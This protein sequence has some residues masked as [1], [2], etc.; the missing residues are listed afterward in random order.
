MECNANSLCIDT[1]NNRLG[2]GTAVPTRSLTLDGQNV[3]SS[4]NY[5]GTEKWVMGNEDTVGDRFILYTPGTGYVMTALIG[6]NVGIGTTTP[7]QKLEVS[8]TILGD[9]DV[10]NGSGA[11]LSQLDSFIGSQ[12]IAGGTNHSRTQCTSAGGI[13]VTDPNYANPI[14]RFTA[15]SCPSGWAQFNSYSTN[16]T[17]TCSW[18]SGWQVGSQGCNCGGYSS[19][20]ATGN[21]WGNLHN[22]CNVPSTICSDAGG[23]HTST[24]YTCWATTTQIGCY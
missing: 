2:I 21:A 12:P 4:Y 20:T 3:Y 16:T 19:C 1:T 23:T 13:L 22:S 9:T 14:C 8:G 18:C 6:G 17:A 24:G 10:C 11:C 7:A 5:N 15:S